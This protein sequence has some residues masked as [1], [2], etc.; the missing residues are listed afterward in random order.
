M[1][2][3]LAMVL[4]PEMHHGISD[5]MESPEASAYRLARTILT[6]MREPTDTMVEAGEAAPRTVGANMAGAEAS[7]MAMIE[8]ALREGK[9][10]A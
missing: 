6:T 7:Y 8:A 2:K 4:L 10:D 5:T 3:R 9:D 1:L